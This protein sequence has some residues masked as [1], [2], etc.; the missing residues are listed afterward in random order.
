MLA[1]LGYYRLEILALMNQICGP[2]VPKT[3]L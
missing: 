3:E 2:L 1:S